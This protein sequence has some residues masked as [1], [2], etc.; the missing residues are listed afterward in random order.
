MW[1]QNRLQ[2]LITRHSDEINIGQKFCGVEET[3]RCKGK[4]EVYT[5]I[6]KHNSSV[7]VTIL[8]E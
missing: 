1:A 5:I 8:S 3:E 7:P 2:Y 6:E 4:Y